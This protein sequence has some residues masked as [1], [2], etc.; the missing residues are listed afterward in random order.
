[1]TTLEKIAVSV[2]FILLAIGQNLPWVKL[3]SIEKK[4]DVTIGEVR[5]LGGFQGREHHRRK[6]DVCG[7]E[8]PEPTGA[9]LNA[10]QWVCR[11][12]IRNHRD[13]K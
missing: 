3:D 4:V 8:R 13:G 1:M 11:D 5:D 7:Y 2:G 6:C 9:R 12:C 10:D